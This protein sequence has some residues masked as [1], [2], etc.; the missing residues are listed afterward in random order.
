MKRLKDWNVIQHSTLLKLHVEQDG[1]QDDVRGIVPKIEF[2]IES[3]LRTEKLFSETGLG[4]VGE[5][6]VQR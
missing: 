4:R 6:F 2:E 1:S 5:I 3:I